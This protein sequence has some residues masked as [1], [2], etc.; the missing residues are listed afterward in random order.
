MAFFAPLIVG[1]LGLTGV[2]A[3]VA[4]LAI[5]VGLSFAANKL[6]PK[7]KSQG[8]FSGAQV[9]LKIDTNPSRTFVAGEKL[10]G[11]SLVF[12]HLSGTN[13]EKL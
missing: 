4:N 13:N 12:W 10:V 7:Q 9:G 8:G 1:A 3:A 11:G 5:G 6:K 2:G